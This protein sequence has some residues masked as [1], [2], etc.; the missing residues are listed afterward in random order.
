MADFT[1][2]RL[3]MVRQVREYG[4][5]NTAIL[6]AM[7]TVPRHF[8]MPRGTESD[9]AVYGDHPTQIGF[10]QTISQPFIVAYMTEL[11]KLEPSDTVLEI[12]TGS[13]YQTAILACI[14]RDVYSVEVV[15]QLA[16]H[17]ANVLEKLNYSN[18]YIKTGDGYAGWSEEGPYQGII[19]TCAP[20]SVPRQLID[21]L[22]D[23]GR[24]VVPVGTADQ[25]L[26]L[27]H[28]TNG[29]IIETSTLP[30]RFVPMIH[31]D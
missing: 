21:Q 15:P 11:L 10:G 23:G 8:F 20:E 29:K 19:V 25:R 12:G 24:I 7:E 4:V 1:E 14:C 18:V 13:G 28:K 3:R 17:A 26:L 16:D 22:A 5:K 27:L 31:K 2:R 9:A 6:A 30:V